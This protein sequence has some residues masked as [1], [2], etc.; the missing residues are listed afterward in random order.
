ME[1]PGNAQKRDGNGL[2]NAWKMSVKGYGNVLGKA[3]K[4][5]GKSQERAWREKLGKG[6]TNVREEVLK[7]PVESF[8]ST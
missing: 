2:G 4:R 7:M 3:R 6:L 8:E 5:L 1:R